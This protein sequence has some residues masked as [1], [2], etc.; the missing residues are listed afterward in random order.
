MTAKQFF[1]KL[2]AFTKRSLPAMA[3]SFSLILA[4]SLVTAVAVTYSG[5]K[6][7]NVAPVQTTPDNNDQQVDNPDPVTFLMPVES[8]TE[9]LPFSQTKLVKYPSLN[10]WQTHE[11]VDFIAIAGTKVVAV[12]DGKIESIETDTM[13][14]TS[15]VIDHGNGLK[16]EYKSLS[17][18]L[19][20]SVGD[21]IKRGEQIGTVSSTSKCEM[22]QG[23]HLHFAVLENGVYKDPY[24]YLPSG[25]K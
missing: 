9:G 1:S 10:K 5:K 22:D 20:V 6:T 4:L 21:K 19:V 2:K 16:T 14:G 25:N 7:T 23:A 15:V 13:F 8:A 11:A 3:I 24:D 12:L 18:D 17:P